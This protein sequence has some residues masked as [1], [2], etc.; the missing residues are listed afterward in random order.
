MVLKTVEGGVTQH[1]MGE[2]LKDMM[3][4]VGEWVVFTPERPD[5]CMVLDNRDLTRNACGIVLDY[6]GGGSEYPPCIAVAWNIDDWWYTSKH[7]PEELSYPDIG[8]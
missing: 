3:P 6:V 5:T 8:G 4:K 1:W 7:L 2:S